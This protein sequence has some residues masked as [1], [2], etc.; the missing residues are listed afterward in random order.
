M[1]KV[2][3]LASNNLISAFA[4]SKKTKASEISKEE[5]KKNKQFEKIRKQLMDATLKELGID[6]ETLDK[7]AQ[8]INSSEN[9]SNNSKQFMDILKDSENV[10]N[11]AKGTVKAGDK[12]TVKKVATFGV[13]VAAVASTQFAAVQAVIASI[14]TT[15]PFVGV[16]LSSA[17]L[18]LYIKKRI[19]VRKGDK[20]DFSE[21]DR[22]FVEHLKEM[23]EKLKM[24]DNMITSDK[25]MILTESSTMKNAEFK[26]FILNYVKEKL[27]YCGLINDVNIEEMN[28]NVITNN[29]PENA[30]QNAKTVDAK[31][32]E[33][34]SKPETKE[35]ISQNKN[36]TEEHSEKDEKLEVSKDIPEEK[37]ELIN[38]IDENTNENSDN[39]IKLI[40]EEMDK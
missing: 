38:L 2:V 16:A 25:E 7:Y 23:E 12:E 36:I 22:A 24:F 19:K 37:Q 30:P 31:E 27:A 11:G 3:A 14:S 1:E 4:G 28:N 5:Q 26:K 13:S 35:T 15:I 21:K 34:N 32:T 20:S 6:Q 17:S 18:A 33:T 29:V 40:E 10:L 9:Q 39:F 8:K